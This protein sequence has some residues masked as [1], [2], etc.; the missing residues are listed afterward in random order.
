MNNRKSLTVGQRGAARC[1]L[2]I[3][4]ASTFQR[5]RTAIGTAI[6][7]ERCKPL[8]ASLLSA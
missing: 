5:E 2:L 4:T 7:V 3:F 1:S 8:V 6:A